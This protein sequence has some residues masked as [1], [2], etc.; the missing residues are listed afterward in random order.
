[1]KAKKQADRQRHALTNIQ[2]K[3]E[4]IIQA[5]KGWSQTDQGGSMRRGQKQKTRNSNTN[6]WY[7]QTSDG[8]W[9]KEKMHIKGEK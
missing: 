3:Q 8:W 5:G 1:M 4:N 2:A 7:T 6:T 9:E